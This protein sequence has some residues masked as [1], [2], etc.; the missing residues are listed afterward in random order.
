MWD[1]NVVRRH[2]QMLLSKEE[3]TTQAMSDVDNMEDVKRT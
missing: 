3:E 1:A 2:Y